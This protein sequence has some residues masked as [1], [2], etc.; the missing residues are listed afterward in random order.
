MS[1]DCVIG[2]LIL[3]KGLNKTQEQHRLFEARH[4]PVRH[5][6]QKGEANP[7]LKIK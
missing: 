3:C 7:L 6:K 5:N 2:C 1:T 4:T